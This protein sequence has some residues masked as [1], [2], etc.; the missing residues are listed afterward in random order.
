MEVMLKVK[1][2]RKVTRK[3]GNKVY[4]HYY[5][6]IPTKVAETLGLDKYVDKE[7]EIALILP[8]I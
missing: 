1:L 6:T 3:V 7:I 2:Q 5:I 8:K 4:Y